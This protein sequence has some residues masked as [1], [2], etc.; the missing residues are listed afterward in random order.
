[1]P[2]DSLVEALSPKDAERGRHVLFDPL[3][4][5]V[6]VGEGGDALELDG[7]GA[8]T[9]GDGLEGFVVGGWGDG[10]AGFP[11]RGVFWGRYHHRGGSGSGECGGHSIRY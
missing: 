11:W 1:M 2:R 4:F 10:L 5:G 8:V 7:S 6:G 3:A 9:A